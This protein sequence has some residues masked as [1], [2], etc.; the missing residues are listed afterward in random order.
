MLGDPLA[1]AR[2]LR[3]HISCELG[4]VFFRGLS[5]SFPDISVT[6]IP[7]PSFSL[8]DRSAPFVSSSPTTGDSYQYSTALVLLRACNNIWLYCMNNTCTKIFCLFSGIFLSR[9][10]LVYHRLSLELFKEILR[11]PRRLHLLVCQCISI[12]LSKFRC[13]VNGGMNQLASA[14]QTVA[15]EVP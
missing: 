1:L 15:V 7:T 6:K 10:T 13:S 5:D 12:N 8:T 4:A 2:A 9:S 3:C 14:S 11:Y